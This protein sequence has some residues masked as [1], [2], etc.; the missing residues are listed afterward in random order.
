[1]NRAFLYID[2]LGFETLVRT[3]SN[4]IDRIFSIFDSLKV[5][6][7]FALHT[8]VFSDTILVF[9]KDDGRTTDYYCTYLV[10]YAQILF[11]RLSEINIYFKGILTFGEFNFTRMSNIQAYYGLALIDAYKDE[12]TLEGF[13]LYVDKRISDEIIVFDKVPFSEK[14]E[15][16]LLCQS[17]KNLYSATRGVLPIDISLLTDTDTFIRIDE[18][19]RFFR[20]IE[21]IMLNHPVDA[22]KAKYKKVYETYKADLPLFFKIFE[23]RGFLP[24]AINSDYTGSINPFA[25]LAEQEL[26]GSKNNS[27]GL[28]QPCN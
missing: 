28:E 17:L 19:L 3:N 6:K 11:Y 24:F 27:I 22:I 20:E 15:F 21:Y 10:E 1:M 14:Y 23:E 7:Q 25:I 9:N 5:H 13:G 26:N 12:G 18:D 16:I 8:V 4:K 2:I